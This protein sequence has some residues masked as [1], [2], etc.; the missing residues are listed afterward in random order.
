[1]N[2]CG[3]VCN[4]S[5]SASARRRISYSKSVR[6]SVRLS[7]TRWCCIKMTRTTIMRSSLQNSPMTSFVVVNFTTKARSTIQN[8]GRGAPH[9]SRI[10]KICNFQPRSCSI[11][12][13]IGWL[14]WRTNRKYHTRFRLVPKSLTLDDLEW[15]IRT[16]LQNR[17]IF[18][19]PIQ[20]FHKIDPYCQ[21]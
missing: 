1:M 9:E 4:A 19:S 14:L 3:H 6:P 8:I 17:C 21:R 20:K 5:Y 2:W 7:V 11:S 15:L 13:I 12:E 16:W 18:W 10:G